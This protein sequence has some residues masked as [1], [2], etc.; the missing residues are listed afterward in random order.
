[1]KKR[2]LT[3][4]VD[5]GAASGKSSTSRALA[6]RFNLLHVDTGAYYRTLTL[7]LLR[8]GI[9][10]VEKFSAAENPFDNLE[11]GTSIEGKESRMSVAGQVPASE[12]IRNDTVNSVV[13]QFSAIPK[14]RK[15]LVEYQR[16]QV[17][18]ARE[19]NF[20]GLIMEGRDIGSN[21]LPDADLRIF[22]TA[23][24]AARER[25]RAAEG[26]SDS[27]ATR[28][29]LDSTRKT[30]PLAC[31]EGATLIDS[32]FLNLEQVVEKISEM[33]RTKLAEEGA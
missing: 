12:E 31:P 9:D 11:L 32:T 2:F 27:I 4:A 6:E 1:M 28:D 19:K 30:A 25:R 15:F 14:V 17:E 18:V 23:D 26:I 3:I 24:V 5:G 10:T 20:A 21:I 7:S 29:K 16:S 33:I 22:L 13:A 8:R